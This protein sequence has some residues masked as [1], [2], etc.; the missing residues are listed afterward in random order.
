[1]R[2][3]VLRIVVLLGAIALWCGAWVLR[4]TACLRPRMR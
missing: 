2:A 3:I 4:A 1:M